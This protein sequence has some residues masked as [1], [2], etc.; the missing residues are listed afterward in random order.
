MS[1][2]THTGYVFNMI[3]RTNADYFPTQNKL[4]CLSYEDAICL[5]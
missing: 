1:T 4:I 3:L 2:H 5:L